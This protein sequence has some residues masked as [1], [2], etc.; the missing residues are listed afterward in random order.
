MATR[1]CSS[2]GRP[3]VTG[4]AFCPNCGAAV[5]PGPTPTGGATVAGAAGGV[6]FAYAPAPA[7]N[8]PGTVMAGLP[9]G[10]TPASR[11]NDLSALSAANLAAILALIAA[12]V[13]FLDLTAGRIGTAL[14]VAPGGTT[15][16]SVTLPDPRLLAVLLIAGAAFLIAE[17]LLWRVGFRHLAHV[18]P[19]FGSPATLA[20]V[21]IVGF[22]VVWVGVALL[23]N[24]LYSAVACAGSGGPLTVS[25]LNTSTFWIGL[26]L[27]VIGAIAALVGEIG[28]LIGIW[29]LGTRYD[30]PLFKAA[31]ILTLIP[32]LSIVAAI[33]ILVGVHNARERVQRLAVGVP[34]A[35]L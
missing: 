25:C 27:V 6:P 32:I 23:L 21:A 35:T 34:P 5:A 10:P 4:A 28:V 29:R 14:T 22:V 24:G 20:L 8:Y 3:L 11:S 31:A 30:D 9:N 17:L 7:G 26:A 19:R 18:D 13:S 2:C 15:S 33:L 12:V 16:T 1:F